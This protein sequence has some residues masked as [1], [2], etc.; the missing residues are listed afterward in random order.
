MAVK[1]LVVTAMNKQYPKPLNPLRRVYCSTVPHIV[2]LLDERC[3]FIV[4]KVNA[5]LQCLSSCTVRVPTFTFAPPIDTIQYTQLG[6]LPT[7]M[8]DLFGFI[9]KTDLFILLI[10]RNI[11]FLIF[12]L[13][14][15][16][17]APCGLRGLP[18]RLWPKCNRLLRLGPPW[19]ALTLSRWGRWWEMKYQEGP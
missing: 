12:F 13:P 15:P 5:W 1:E 14:M 16:P 18:F 10:V 2:C 4:C 6:L 7:C 3:S 17:H 8:I 11:I 9:S 19:G